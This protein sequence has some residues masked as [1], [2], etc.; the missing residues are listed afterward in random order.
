MTQ[1]SYSPMVESSHEISL[2]LASQPD[3][4]ARDAEGRTAL[5]EL[6]CVAGYNLEGAKLLLRYGADVNLATA[7]DLG[8]TPLMAAAYCRR[9]GLADLL[10]Q[11][12][13]DVNKTNQNGETALWDVVEGAIASDERYIYPGSL[14]IVLMLIRHGVNLRHQNQQGQGIL[15]T[16]DG[17]EALRPLLSLIQYYEGYS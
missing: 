11:C 4:N 9:V 17:N 15:Q 5:Y 2:W 10:I 16:F 14:E 8:Q 13:A 1:T 6:A 3:V 7:D 12:G